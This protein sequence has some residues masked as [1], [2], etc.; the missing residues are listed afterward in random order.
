M[1]DTLYSYTNLI[2]VQSGRQGLSASS[3]WDNE[4]HQSNAPQ[5][6]SDEEVN[7]TSDDDDVEEQEASESSRG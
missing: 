5:E 2:L 3:H 7:M 6:G 4:A 1:L